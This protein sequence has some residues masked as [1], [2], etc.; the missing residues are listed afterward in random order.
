[1]YLAE[2]SQPCTEG[3]MPVEMSPL[4]THGRPNWGNGRLRVHHPD[5]SAEVPAQHAA[6]IFI[7]VNTSPRPDGEADLTYRGA[8]GAPH[9]GTRRPHP[10]SPRSPRC[11]SR[12]D[13]V[14]RRPWPSTSSAP[15]RLRGSPSNP[16]SRREGQQRSRT[17]STRT[18]SCRRRR[19]A[20][21]GSHAGTVRADRRREFSSPIHADC[22]GRSRGAVPRH[23]HRQAPSRSVRPI[24]FGNEDRL[25][26]RSRGRMRD[27]WSGYPVVRG[28][29][30]W[31]NG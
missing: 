17:S 14:S 16:S 13:S 2:R 30:N 26:E 20:C 10:S 7:C 19:P 25:R 9:R 11:R 3:R 1:M 22:R 15:C 27:G 24:L 6:I 28:V 21:R 5:E 31:T 12:P 29:G 8:G 18:E 23:R 4:G